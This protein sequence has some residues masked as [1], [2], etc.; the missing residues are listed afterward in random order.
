VTL[1]GKENRPEHVVKKR[2]TASNT[3]GEKS[4]HPQVKGGAYDSVAKKN[5]A[6]VLRKKVIIQKGPSVENAVAMK[7]ATIME[8]ALPWG[9]YMKRGG[10]YTA[11]KSGHRETLRMKSKKHQQE[12]KEATSLRRTSRLVSQKVPGKKKRGARTSKRGAFRE[13]VAA[14]GSKREHRNGK[15]D[16]HE[17]RT[18]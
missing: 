1:A 12:K 2:P 7:R 15:N 16:P 17:K 4:Y 13:G 6:P 18:F 14:A 11:R 9:L 3:G 8:R 10:N 5:T